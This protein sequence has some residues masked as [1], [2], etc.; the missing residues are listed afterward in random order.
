MKYLLLVACGGLGAIFFLLILMLAIIDKKGM[1][2][3]TIQVREL[4]LKKINKLNENR[5]IKLSQL[6]ANEEI[7]DYYIGISTFWYILF[8]CLSIVSLLAMA[9]FAIIFFIG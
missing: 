5:K 2:I 9:V 3:H 8:S 7:K 4:N 6:P 1:V